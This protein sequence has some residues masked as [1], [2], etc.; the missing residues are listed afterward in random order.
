M[1]GLR[2]RT[3]ESAAGTSTSQPERSLP[4][5]RLRGPTPDCGWGC[6]VHPD[7]QPSVMTKLAARVRNGLII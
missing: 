1:N 3:F 2:R 4:L 5:K 7:I 6:E